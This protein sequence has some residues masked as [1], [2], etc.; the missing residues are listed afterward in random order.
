MVKFY[1]RIKFDGEV[2]LNVQLDMNT[3]GTKSPQI[4]IES[5]A[6]LSQHAV[7]LFPDLHWYKHFLS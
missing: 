5:Q 6:T 7:S 4:K 2:S 3:L 1:R